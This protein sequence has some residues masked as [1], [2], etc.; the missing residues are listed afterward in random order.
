MQKEANLALVL[1]FFFFNFVINAKPLSKKLYEPLEFDLM[2]SFEPVVR[3]SVS[4]SCELNAARLER[5]SALLLTFLDLVFNE[6]TSRLLWLL[7]SVLRTS[8]LLAASMVASLSA[9]SVEVV[10]DV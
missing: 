3:P 8:A 5:L 4:L 1:L 6:Q 10:V 2:I 7:V 9:F